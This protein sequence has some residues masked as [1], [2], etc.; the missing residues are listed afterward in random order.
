VGEKYKRRVDAKEKGDQVGDL[1]EKNNLNSL[2]GKTVC[3]DITE[4]YS[5]IS[6]EEGIKGIKKN[7]LISCEDVGD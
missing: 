6:M 5:F 2:Y 7:G 4:K 1:M 3:K